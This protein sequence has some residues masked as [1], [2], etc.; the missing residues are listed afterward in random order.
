MY[1]EKASM[2]SRSSSSVP[3]ANA[4]IGQVG[5]EQEGGGR[6]GHG[7]RFHDPP[8]PQRVAQRGGDEGDQQQVLDQSRSLLRM[9]VSTLSKVLLMRKA[10]RPM[11]MTA[12]STSKNMPS[13]TIIG[14]P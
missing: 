1:A 8:L 10:N 2:Y 7:H 6:A 9:V 11:M 13:S 12:T 4:S 3:W 5:G 14:M